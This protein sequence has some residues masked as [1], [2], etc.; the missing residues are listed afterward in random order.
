MVVAKCPIC[1]E[2]LVIENFICSEYDNLEQ[3]LEVRVAG[4][5][6]NCKK[7]YLW[8]IYYDATDYGEVEDDE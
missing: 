7:P 5:C 2:P 4:K 6:T 8:S 3:G 1:G